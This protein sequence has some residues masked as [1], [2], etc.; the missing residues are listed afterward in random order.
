MEGELPDEPTPV[1][2]D[3]AAVRRNG[4]DV[5]AHHLWRIADKTLQ[6][7]EQLAGDGI[8]AEVIDLRSLRPLDT[9]T[10]VASV[11]RTH[12]AVVIDEGWRT[13]SLSAEIAAQITEHAFYDLDAPVGAGLQ[14]RSPHPLRQAPGG[15]RPPAG[16]IDRRRSAGRDR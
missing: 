9:P 10:I 7:A 8:E 11:A 15:G 13:G 5:S 4:G 6:A 16:G 1:D 12:R 14:R 3:R 2:I